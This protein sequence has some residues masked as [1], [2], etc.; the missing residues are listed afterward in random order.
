MPRRPLNGRALALAATAKETQDA[1]PSLVTQLPH[2]ELSQSK[3]VNLEDLT[4]PDPAT[5][6]RYHLLSNLNMPGTHI[7]VL[8]A[9]T[10][11]AAMQMRLGATSANPDNKNSTQATH[12]KNMRVA[13][14]NLA[15]DKNP[16]GGW[17]R[18]S[19]AQEEALCY[20]SSL[21]LSLQRGYYPFMPFDGVYT[22]DVVIVRSS[23]AEGHELLVPGVPAAGLP[24]VSVIS[25]AGIRHP[26]IST[27]KQAFAV[28]KDRNL[29]K[30][31]MRLVLR[32]AAHERHE[33]LVLGAI[34]CGAFRNPPRDVAK[35]WLEVLQE[36]EFKGGW[37]RDIWFAIFDVKN[38]GNFQVFEEI[39]GGQIV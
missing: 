3:K 1:L 16:G 27:D 17:L 11:E 39:L 30:D 38:E 25:V 28:K 4:P 32:I 21:S 18:G 15:S 8:N 13:V 31:K 7:K 33:M 5:C 34:G 19:A 20:R 37:W 22:G 26:M 23:M 35:C 14:L 9:D 6:P 12:P 36:D 2:L 24:V 29:T 10:L